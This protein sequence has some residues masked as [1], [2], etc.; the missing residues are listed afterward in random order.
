ML[1]QDTCGMLPWR[2]TMPVLQV[3]GCL[4]YKLSATS[5]PPVF[6]LP[7]LLWSISVHV[8]LTSVSFFAFTN[9]FHLYAAPDLGTVFF[10]NC[11]AFMMA[12]VPLFPVSLTIKS[13]KMAAL[14]HDMSN[15]VVVHR[16]HKI[17]PKN[18]IVM[19]TAVIFVVFSTWFA[20]FILRSVFFEC[21]MVF[22]WTLACSVT[23][24]M[25]DSCLSALLDL[26]TS[27][28]LLATESTV[29]TVS[30]LLGPD[31]SFSGED[32]TKEALLALHD[33]ESLIREVTAW[34]ETVKQCFFPVLTTFL[35]LSVML[36]IA[37][38]YAILKGKFM[39]GTTIVCFLFSFYIMGVYSY[40][41][42]IFTDKVSLAE[43]QL[44]DLNMRSKNTN[45]CIKM[46]S[47]IARLSP[48]LTFNMCGCYTLSYSSFL[49]L[50]NTVLT[51]LVIIFQIGGNDITKFSSPSENDLSDSEK[52]DG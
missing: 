38:P 39:G 35:L 24:F 32:N 19:M 51:Y 20:C 34:Q 29:A 9:I 13:S 48:L 31:G 30:K 25:P 28:L 6:S 26:M 46:N 4:P 42:Q 5:D 27:Y 23:I 44:R 7:L 16:K 50:M 36:A 41:G 43:K 22:L 3:F 1:P 45:F 37:C 10:M 40:Y 21:V 17:Y 8:F 33:L 14:L 52:T 47:V 11:V 2:M 49:G 15:I 18:L 12:T